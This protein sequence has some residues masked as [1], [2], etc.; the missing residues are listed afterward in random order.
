MPRKKKS[1]SGPK[2][3]TGINK[4][5]FIRDHADKSPKEIVELAK[6][7]GI[8]LGLTFVYSVRTQDKARK[9]KSGGGAPAKRGPK[10]KGGRPAASSGHSVFSADERHLLG[11]IK[12][13]GTA[14]AGEL[15]G[16]AAAFMSL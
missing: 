13:V 6:A 3:K 1:A 14:R 5:A 12:K 8:D 10:P 4:S 2:G 7:K 16:L 11:L 15:V 9:K